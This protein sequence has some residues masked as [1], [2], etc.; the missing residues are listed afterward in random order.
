MRLTWKS[1]R[2]DYMK[3]HMKFLSLILLLLSQPLWAGGY[4]YSSIDTY[5]AVS[6]LYYKSLERS[7]GDRGFMGSSSGGR[8]ITNINIYDP[9]TGSSSLLFK[10]SPNGK[11][12]F[13]FFESGYRDGKIEF[14]DTNVSMHIRNNAN[15]TKRP[16]KDQ[17][18]VGV[19]VKNTQQTILYVA[20]KHG[21]NMKKVVE[22]P[23]GDD[24]HIDVRNSKLRVM[25]QTEQGLKID[26]YEW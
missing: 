1:E 5:D 14:G 13:L 26:N 3:R 6:G 16:V 24:W 2:P 4:Y 10:E 19:S 12:Y 8:E 7:T 11:I 23:E 22:I 20:D 18:L 25:H 15:V 9:V 21:A 17:L